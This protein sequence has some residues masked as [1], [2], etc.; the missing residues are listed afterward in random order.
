M[1]TRTIVAA[2]LVAA[3]PA[4]AFLKPKDARD[5]VTA[6]FVGFDEQAPAGAALKP[7]DPRGVVCAQR[8]A[9]APFEIRLD[10][11]NTTA[12]P[13]SGDLRIWLNDDWDISVG[14]A[15]EQPQVIVLP[16]HSTN[17][18]VATAIPKP[19]RVLPE[20]YPVHATF[21]FPG[22]D[23]L[24]PIAVFDAIAAPGTACPAAQALP[25]ANLPIRLA[26]LPGSSFSQLPG[27]APKPILEDRETG[28]FCDKGWFAADG[29]LRYGFFNQPPW[30]TGGGFGW[31]DIPVT[32]PKTAPLTLRLSAAIRSPL[33]AGEGRSDGADYKVFVVE[34]GGR[35]TEVCSAFV[36]ALSWTDGTADL[37]PWAGQ[38]V[39]I[40]LWNGCGP[41]NEPSYDRCL[42]GDIGISAGDSPL[43]TRHSALRQQSWRFPLAVRG[44]SWTA[45]FTPGPC[46]LLD[47]TISFTDGV[48][49]LSFSGFTCAIDN[50]MVGTGP[51][52]ARCTGYEVEAPCP[53]AQAPS[54]A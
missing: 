48:R 12:A 50:V 28:A 16:P 9:S 47:G 10:L 23:A 1:N 44:E 6:R 49:T 42:W 31:R 17:S 36:K 3:L 34:E 5:G 14:G 22:G 43:G 21:A 40:R 24:H 15:G 2:V 37:S 7:N 19:G 26:L 35:T 30:R 33:R 46:G 32:L 27:A 38:N 18:F 52:D 20:L 39:A 13:V 51:L 53:D 8:D 11:A 4:F 29:D 41:A 45:T 25:C 54:C